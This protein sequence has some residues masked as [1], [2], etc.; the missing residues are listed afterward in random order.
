M[1]VNSLMKFIEKINFENIS[2]SKKL[3][4]NVRYRKV[5]NLCE[6]YCPSKAIQLSRDIEINVEHCTGCGI[7]ASVCPNGVFELVEKSDKDILKEINKQLATNQ[8]IKFIC[9]KCN[10]VLGSVKISRKDL[11]DSRAKKC[12]F[13]V[14]PCLGRVQETFV[15]YAFRTG[16]KSVEFATE[17]CD[18]DCICFP[19][20]TDIIK[21]TL[22][23]SNQLIKV[24]NA[25]SHEMD[26]KII[27]ESQRLKL[28][29]KKKLNLISKVDSSTRRRF[30]LDG[31]NTGVVEA[32]NMTLSL[33]L[34][35]NKKK[36]KN[37]E[38]ISH[39]YQSLPAK[40]FFL[41][42]LLKIKN[43]QQNVLERRSSKVLPIR[44]PFSNVKIK[45]ASC[46]ACY[47]CTVVCPTGALAH[48]DL[49][50][51]D[52]IYFSFGKCTGCG[53]CYLACP[54]HAIE[55]ENSVDLGKI[56]DNA[57]VLIK[58]PKK[59]CDNCGTM[60]VPTTDMSLCP[61]CSK[62]LSIKDAFLQ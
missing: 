7:C 12:G 6:K 22:G 32:L 38:E 56:N 51:N 5:C 41:L 49:D 35:K 48:V 3:C 52:I 37:V 20:A 59:K 24:L 19:E 60:F 34:K 13:I 43:P 42:N 8:S 30:L 17:Y 31:I 39:W 36:N 62:R 40:R 55:Y 25:E 23:F 28:N 45:P 27:F 21:Q 57:V 10:G 26:N 47:T 9:N 46:Q 18:K 61:Q 4:P 15:L 1:E 44:L 29:K 14:V 16:A 11:K 54:E 2:L 58:H 33:N 53:V 50:T